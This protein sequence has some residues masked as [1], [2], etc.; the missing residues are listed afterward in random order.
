MPGDVCMGLI[1]VCV[2][3]GSSPNMQSCQWAVGGVCHSKNKIFKALLLYPFHFTF[4]ACG[5]SEFAWTLWTLL[6]L[7]LWTVLM[8]L[9]WTVLMLLLWTVLML[10]L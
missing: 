2:Y 1:E 3:G 5:A 6:L 8:L 9:L 7:L 10:F 4:L